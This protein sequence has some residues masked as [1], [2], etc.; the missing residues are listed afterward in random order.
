MNQ[1]KKVYEVTCADCV[2]SYHFDEPTK[3]ELEKSLKVIGWGKNSS[4]EWV[5]ENCTL[6]E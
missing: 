3:R 2:C 6:P 1:I 4:K 5:C